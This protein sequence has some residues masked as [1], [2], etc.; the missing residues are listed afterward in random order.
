MEN[1]GSLRGNCGRGEVA[2][3]DRALSGYKIQSCVGCLSVAE[4]N[5][6]AARFL[7]STK[8]TTKETDCQT[9]DWL[10]NE[11]SRTLLAVAARDP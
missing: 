5:T 11:D 1:R 4:I 8:E 9:V 6:R 3:T 7:R 2:L 10:N